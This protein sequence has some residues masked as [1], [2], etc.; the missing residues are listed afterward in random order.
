MALFSALAL[1]GPVV[2]LIDDIHWADPALLDILEEI[3]DRVVG[4]LMVLCTSRPDLAMQRPGWGGGRRET[5]VVRLEPLGGADSERLVHLLL[6]IDDL[7]ARV[8]EQILARA[9][10]NPFFLEEILRQLIDTGV[11]RRAGDRWSAAVGIEEVDIPDTV[12]GVLAARIDMLPQD[13]RRV[14]RAASVVGRTFWTGSVDLLAPPEGPRPP[15]VDDSLRR[16]EERDLVLARLGSALVGEVEYLFKHILTRDVAYESIPRRERVAAHVSVARWI[17]S[18]TGDRTREFAEQLA[19]HYATAVQLAADTGVPLDGQV[20]A[21]A[22]AWLLRAGTDARRRSAISTAQRLAAQAVDLSA[23]DVERCAALEL[24][25]DAFAHDSFGELG[26]PAIIEAAELADRSPDIP[27]EHAAL[28]YAKAVEYPVRWPGMMTSEPDERPVR[29]MLERGLALAPPGDSPG[30]ARLLAMKAGWPFAFPESVTDDELPARRAA[31][32][33][34]TEMALRLGDINLAS[35]ALDAVNSADMHH[36][37]YAAAVTSWL[38][39]WELRDRLTDELEIADL[40]AVGAW[41]HHEV[42]LYAESVRIARAAPAGVS[43]ST[44]LHARAWLVLSLYRLGR[45]GDAVAEFDEILTLLGDRWQ[46]PPLYVTGAFATVAAVRELRGEHEQAD[47]L[48]GVVRRVPFES[49][50]CYPDRVWLELVTGHEERA[51]RALRQLP[52][53]WGVNAGATWAVRCDAAWVE[54]DH[55]VARV[56]AEGARGHGV[57]AGAKAVPPFADRLAGVTAWHE[58]DHESARA[59]LLVAAE[60][61][62]GVAM[63]FEAART[64]AVLARLGDATGVAALSALRSQS[65]DVYADL[66]VVRDRM[67]D[68]LPPA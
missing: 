9:E 50:R 59:A 41:T 52:Y 32:L 45:W 58:G 21:D 35:T 30:L 42:G 44:T 7:P 47:R 14:L 26:W 24:Q 20:R 66:R 34:A 22:V 46:A 67:L 5:T 25:A 10:G 56:V 33:E 63:R 37:N 28:L 61:F 18:A 29:S 48:G 16:L 12:Q 6:D 53:G 36:G 60:G 17:E 39:R 54:P 23:T 51:Q 43:L 31:G 2:A 64:R 4:G 62:D 27:D 40:Y 13:D 1:R 3:D 65:D 49:T 19:H 68:R 11:V 55:A 15:A 38:R 57:W 8:R